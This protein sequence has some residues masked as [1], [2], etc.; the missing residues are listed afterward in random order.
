MK[1]FKI[2]ILFLCVNLYAQDTQIISIG[3]DV[4]LLING[5]YSYDDTPVLDHYFSIVIQRED[6]PGMYQIK[7]HAVPHFQVEG[8]DVQLLLVGQ[9]PGTND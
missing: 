8:V 6:N 7:L 4:Q 1:Y 2:L 9:M 5:A 3:A